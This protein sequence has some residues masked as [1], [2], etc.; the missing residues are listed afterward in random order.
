[1]L[2]TEIVFSWK[3]WLVLLWRMKWVVQQ[4]LGKPP[5]IYLFWLITCRP[6]ASLVLLGAAVCTFVRLFNIRLEPAAG[7]W[8]EKQDSGW[9]LRPPQTLTRPSHLILL[10]CN[11][12]FIV[13]L[14]TAVVCWSWLKRLSCVLVQ[15]V[16]WRTRRMRMERRPRWSVTAACA[17]AGTGSAPPWPALVSRNTQVAT[18]WFLST[19]MWTQMPLEHFWLICYLFQDKTTALDESTDTGAEMTEEEWN[20]RVAELNKHQV[21]LCD[22]SNHIKKIN[23]TAMSSGLSQSNGSGSHYHKPVQNTHAFRF[24]SDVNH[25]PRLVESHS[26][27]RLVK[28]P[29]AQVSLLVDSCGIQPWLLT[30]CFWTK[31]ILKTNCSASTN[32]FT[33]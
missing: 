31:S 27:I 2:C 12:G 22:L 6:H 4:F 24:P 20:L 16:P 32:Q 13:N 17:H 29:G 28:W 25:S 21:W 30:A 19:H 8:H 15:N 1:M 7:M 3:S 26:L 10:W 23:K 18:L 9:T 11:V 33:E 14:P 5:F